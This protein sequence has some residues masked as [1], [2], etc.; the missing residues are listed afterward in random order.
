MTLRLHVSAAVFDSDNRIDRRQRPEC[1]VVEPN[2]GQ[3]W[4]VVQHQRQ[5]NQRSDVLNV[6]RQF[7]LASR[8]ILR[9]GQ[10]RRVS[11]TVRRILC[12]IDRLNECGVRHTNQNRNSSRDNS[13]RL[14]D[15]FTTQPI[16]QTWRFTCRAEDKH[17][18]HPAFDDMIQQTVKSLDVQRVTCRKRRDQRRNNA[19]Q[20]QGE[21][22]HWI[23]IGSR[24]T[25]MTLSRFHVYVM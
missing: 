3:S 2:L 6:C 23:T 24:T 18:R 19:L 8:K 13:H 9:R 10:H 14:R 11:S 21:P 25:C 4:H 16:T 7:R 17:G 1:F 22:A 5:R 15:H 20:L 12:Q